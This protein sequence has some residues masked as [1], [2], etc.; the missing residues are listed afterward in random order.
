MRVSF[1]L[2]IAVALAP[3][4]PAQLMNVVSDYLRYGPMHFDWSQPVGPRSFTLPYR[5]S[6]DPGQS[7]SVEQYPERNPIPRLRMRMRPPRPTN[8]ARMRTPR[9]GYG[10]GDSTCYFIRS[11]Y[12]RREAP[13]S[14]A[15]QIVGQAVCTM[16]SR[17]RQKQAV[18]PMPTGPAVLPAAW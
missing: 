3:A 18:K 15:T 6:D 9:D 13:G 7:F 11:Y 5:L 10:L 12:A 16:S 2:A 17:F 4:C 8:D 1:V 14:D